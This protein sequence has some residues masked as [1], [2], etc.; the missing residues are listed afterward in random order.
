[1]AAKLYGV[2]AVPCTPFD[3]AGEVDEQVLRRHLRFLLHQGRVHGIVPAGSTGEFAFLSEV[4][5][6][7]V[8]DITIEEVN[9]KVPV[10]VGAA[11]CSTR[12]TIRYAQRAQAGGVQGLMVVPPYYG[13]LD[14]EEL[15]RHYATVAECIDIPI[16][17]Y[18]NPGASGSDVVPSLLARLAETGR[19]I[20]VKES[21]G[22]MQRV[23]EIMRLCGDKMQVICGCDTLP[24]EMFSMDVQAWFAAPANIVPRQCVELFELAVER[25]NY[26]D[27]RDLYFK[28][29][30]LFD[31][32]ESTGQYVQLVKAGLDILGMS[33]GLPRPP[34]RPASSD[35]Q[36]RLKEILVNILA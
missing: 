20:A 2:Y 30:P 19:I 12:D 29:L 35:K 14:E 31:M 11:A 23:A 32:M 15:Y 7:R 21:S 26:A 3:G 16:I 13:H 17:V 34:L 6:Q 18:N 24:L 36:A 25:H 28:L 9:G 8:V 1:M 33:V 4:E 22:Q 10:F 5:R 27:A